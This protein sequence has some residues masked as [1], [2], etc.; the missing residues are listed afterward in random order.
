LDSAIKEQSLFDKFLFSVVENVDNG[1]VDEEMNSTENE[2]FEGQVE[3]GGAKHYYMEPHAVL[4]IPEEGNEMLIYAATQD[5]KSEQD[6][7]SA[8]TGI[9][10]NKLH[11]KTKRVGGSFGGKGGSGFYAAVAVACHKLRKPV[12]MVIPRSIDTLITS[13]RGIYRGKY[14]VAVSKKDHKITAID[15]DVQTDGGCAGFA[16]F[17]A[18]EL[19]LHLDNCYN[20]PN[21]RVNSKVYKTNR[22]MNMPMRGAGI[23][24]GNCFS[25]FLMQD[26]AMKLNIDATEFREKHLLKDGDQLMNHQKLDS[27]KPLHDGWNILKNDYNYQTIAQ[28]VKEFNSQNKFKKRGVALTPCRYSLMPA[29]FGFMLQGNAL[30]HCNSDGTVMLSHDGIELGQGIN[31]KM[32]QMCAEE[33]GIPVEDIYCPQV[34]SQ[35][36]TGMVGMG[37][38]KDTERV[39]VAVRDACKQILERLENLKKIIKNPE[40]SFKQLCA[41]AFLCKVSLAAYG[42]S[43]IELDP[44]LAEVHGFSYFTWASCLSVVE[45]DVLTGK[46]DILE[47]DTVQ[48][49]GRSINPSVDIGQ[50]EGG[51]MM[52]L[53]WLTQEDLCFNPKNG[54]MKSQPEEYEIASPQNVPK[55][56]NIN[57]LNNS[58]NNSIHNMKGIGEPPHSLGVSVVCALKDAIS[59][60]RRDIGLGP[61]EEFFQT[62]LNRERIQ[63]LCGSHT[64][65]SSNKSEN[66]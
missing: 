56:F 34:S 35:S 33:L 64:K 44:K 45:I 50:I 66:N 30:L 31:I 48:D 41:S 42:H 60:A 32:A 17:L 24:Q 57:I 61:V 29:A 51:F 13:R 11:V 8:A 4:C 39:G 18:N 26:V 52:G 2:T 9:P 55:K 27:Y 28:Q 3:V 1:K 12:R 53:S 21:I 65:V 46:F 6:N 23:P 10:R 37:G 14:K 62:P 40:A 19:V 36:T 7:C 43:Y 49:L 16:P 25:E 63:L 59:N 58:D 38:S 15:W 47:C 22:S 54:A 5:V 20:F